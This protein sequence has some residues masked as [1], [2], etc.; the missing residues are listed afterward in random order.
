[1]VGSLE[2]SSI[3]V[4]GVWPVSL[5]KASRR[6]TE[7]TTLRHNMIMENAFVSMFKARSVLGQHLEVGGLEANDGFAI[8]D[9]AV[10]DEIDGFGEGHFYDFQDFILAK[11]LGA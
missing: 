4:Q 1:M 9:G 5:S 7:K 3:G 8:F 6:K 10:F 2:S 11:V